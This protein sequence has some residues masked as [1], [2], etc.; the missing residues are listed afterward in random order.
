MLNKLNILK[1]GLTDKSSLSWSQIW[2]MQ[3]Y[4]VRINTGNSSPDLTRIGS[5]MTQHNNTYLHAVLPVQT[6]MKA[7]LLQDNGTV[8][9]YLKSTD[10]TKKADGT[11]SNLAGTD[12]QVMIEVPD[13]Y[14]KVENPSSGIYD[15]KISL[16]PLSGYIKVN[17][18]YIGAY[19][20]ALQR[21]NSKLASVKNATTD[22]R[23]G[24]NNAAWD[25]ANNTLLS[26]P[27][28]LISKTNF[29]T[30]ARNRGSNK[31]NL[32][33]LYQHMLIYEL[34]LIEYATLNTQK[35][36]NATLTA[37][38]YRQGGLGVG[39]TNANSTE[40]SNFCSYY[41]FISC[42][43]S[44][45][46]ANGSG[47]VSV[48]KT[49]FGGSAVNRTFTV[50]RYRGI[51]N[52]FGHIWKFLDGASV[53]HESTG[54]ASKLYTCDTPANFSDNTETNYEYRGNLPSSSGWVKTM[55]HDDKA[56][57][58]SKEI[59][60]DTSL[61]WCDYYYTPGLIMAWRALLC[62]GSA[63]NGSNAGFGCLF[64]NYTES[65]ADTHIGARLCY[66]P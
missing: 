40:W 41:P 5:D 34:F 14:R 44:N 19:E 29:R 4:G 28:T 43:D 47:E 7:C 38:G 18:F 53:Y 49:D 15:L 30:Y 10:W 52:P 25:A 64:S 48:V 57:L 26:K 66:I 23:G 39:V 56:I 1:P 21:S 13:Y 16:S 36:V 33:T 58:I 20:A 11:A 24:N 62:G 50:P 55:T 60:G 54:G 22:Y 8:N 32:E 51:E 65:A 46:L 61:Y 63:S 37:E 3:W 9:Y 27:A 45:S 6:L 2:A 35:A 42:G 59:G 31:W 12:G 17:K